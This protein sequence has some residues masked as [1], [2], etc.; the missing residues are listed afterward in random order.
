MEYWTRTT[1]VDIEIDGQ[2]IPPGE[3][4]VSMLRSANR[5]EEVFNEPLPRC[6]NIDAG[7]ATVAYPSLV[8][9]M[10]IYD[11]MSISLTSR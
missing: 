5:D 8:T 10:P 1:K 11:A 9:T 2:P 7:P 3:R 6:H 4:I